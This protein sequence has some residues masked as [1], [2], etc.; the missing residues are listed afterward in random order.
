MSIPILILGQSGSGKSS[1][2]LHLPPKNTFIFNVCNK[3]LPFRGAGRMYTEINSKS[4]PAGN[5]LS[6]DDY[7]AI[8][9]T[10]RYIDRKRREIRY[11][12]IDDS[13]YLIVNEFMRKH[14]NKGKGN[15]VYSVYSDI[16]THFWRLIRD[17]KL[18]RNDVFV[19]FMHHAEVTESGIIKA[20]T[21]GKLLDEKIDVPGMFTIVLLAKRE[22]QTNVFLT[23]NNGESPAKTPAGMFE[24]E[25]IPN[26]LLLVATKIQNYYEGE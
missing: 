6:T 25:K 16:G 1:S 24:S 26:D 11:V 2:I 15:D 17:S 21:V 3:E 5:K 4:N 10:M 9:K 18:L 8:D 19:F 23:Q 22:E 7:G 20:K 12:I 13:Q 14:S